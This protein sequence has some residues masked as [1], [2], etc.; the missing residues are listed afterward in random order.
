MP[1]YVVGS[2]GAF[3]TI[4][5]IAAMIAGG[6]TPTRRIC[7]R[8]GLHFLVDACRNGL[9]SGYTPCKHGREYNS[10][11]TAIARDLASSW[12]LLAETPPILPH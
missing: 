3:W 4:D 7:W 11:A 8:F 2:F 5:R 9:C 10:V 12:K 1:A 6:M